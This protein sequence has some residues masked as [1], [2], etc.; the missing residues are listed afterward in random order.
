MLEYE[1][2]QKRVLK[3]LTALLENE[4]ALYSPAVRRAVELEVESLKSELKVEAHKTS[5]RTNEDVSEHQSDSFTYCTI[6]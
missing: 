4:N 6:Q 1:R 3:N 5:S 2:K